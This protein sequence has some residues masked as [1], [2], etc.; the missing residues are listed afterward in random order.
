MTNTNF[1]IRLGTSVYADHVKSGHFGNSRP[2]GHGISELKINF[3]PGYRAYYIR[4][5]KM[6]VILLCAPNKGPAQEDI[7]QA[8]TYALDYWKGRVRN[9]KSP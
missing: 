7:R 5:R 9:H 2:I 8:Y 4:D 3:G 6:V 1:Y